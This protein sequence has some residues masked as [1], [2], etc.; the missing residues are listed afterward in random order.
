MTS[1]TAAASPRVGGPEGPR[2]LFIYY[3][4]ASGRAAAARLAIEALQARL[5][6]ALPGLR[7]QLLR[8]P[9]EKD[10]LQTWMEVYAHPDGV[11][12]RAQEHIE[13]AARE[14]QALCPGPRHVEV[15]VPCAS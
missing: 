6:L 13:A 3:R 11:S 10:G 8:R 1:S 7:T 2:Q 15:F 4:V 14:L 5:R 12:L 9:D